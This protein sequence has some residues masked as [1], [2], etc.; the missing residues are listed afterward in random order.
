[1][2]AFFFRNRK[3]HMAKA[4][5]IATAMAPTTVPAIAPVPRPELLEASEVDVGEMGLVVPAVEKRTELAADADDDSVLVDDSSV[6]LSMVCRKIVK[7][8]KAPSRPQA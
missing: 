7:A 3:N 1:M 6:V 2:A 4:K 5:K 8:L